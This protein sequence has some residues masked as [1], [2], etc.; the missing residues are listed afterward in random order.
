MSRCSRMLSSKWIG[1]ELSLSAVSS[2]QAGVGGTNGLCLDYELGLDACRQLVHLECQ[3]AAVTDGLRRG[4][5]H[6]QLLRHRQ[7]HNHML[8]V[9]G[10]LVGDA[11]REG[12]RLADFERVRGFVDV[13]GQAGAA[14]K[15]GGGLG[16]PPGRDRPWP[17][18]D[19]SGRHP[20]GP[21]G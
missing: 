6:L 1:P 16:A 15:P 11:E 12:A 10:A 2:A 20:C 14:R 9:R 3:L 19:R 13:Q 8:G 21:G 4:A 17:A 18:G 7:R 5:A